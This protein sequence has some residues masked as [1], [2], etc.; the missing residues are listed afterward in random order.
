MKLTTIAAGIVSAIIIAAPGFAEPLTTVEKPDLGD[1]NLGDIG[2]EKT[3]TTNVDRTYKSETYSVEVGKVGD[4]GVSVYG[5]SESN[6]DPGGDVDSNAN[7]KDSA[8]S[9]GISVDF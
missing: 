4:H 5:K 6:F 7:M 3:T 9:A 2:V 1:L 8:T